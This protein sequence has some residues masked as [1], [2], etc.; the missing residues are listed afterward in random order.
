MRLSE[1]EYNALI[2]RRSRKAG[3]SPNSGVGTVASQPRREDDDWKAKLL[4]PTKIIR[5]SSKD[6]NKTERRFLNEILQPML[7]LGSLSEIGEHESIT[8]KLANGL[9]YSPDFPTWAGDQLTFFEVKGARVWEDSLIKL[10]VAASRYQH[11]RF[12]LCKY[13]RGEWIKQEVLA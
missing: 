9:R 4:P 7:A 5:Q 12:F 1:D 2:S 3:S 11:F 8:L 13:V 6:L 10:K